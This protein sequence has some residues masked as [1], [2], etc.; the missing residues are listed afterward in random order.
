MQIRKELSYYSYM[1]KLKEKILNQDVLRILVVVLGCVFSALVLTFSVLAMQAIIAND[2]GAASR[3]LLIVFIILGLSRLVS[4]IKDRSKITF[5]RFLI[6]FLFDVA[7]GVMTMFG[8]DYPMFYSICAGAYCLTIV[9]SRIFKIIAK[10][11]IRSYI[12]NGIIIAFALLLAIGCF[13]PSEVSE[14][15][16]IILLVCAIVSISAFLEVIS[17]AGSFL[18]ARVLFKIILRTYALEVILGLFTLMVASSILFT[19][20]EPQ[21]ESFPDALWYS[22]AVVTTIGFGDYTAVTP[23]GRILTVV[24][25]LYGI[26]VVAVLTSIIVNF[27]NETAGKHDVKEFKDIKDEEKKK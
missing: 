27:Y 18:K 22:F 3:N 2:L 19:M 5:Y 13:I 14:T 15:A 4:F 24:I 6:L 9:V 8:K 21:I 20:F 23:L 25:G 12:F 26:V 1:A 17:S 11:N 10:R 16:D 7:I